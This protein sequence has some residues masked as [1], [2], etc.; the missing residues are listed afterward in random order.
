MRR[1]IITEDEKK[2]ILSKYTESNDEL[3][4]YLEENYP[5]IEIS[6]EFKDILGKYM[7]MIDDKPIILKNNFERITKK[8]DMEIVDEFPNLSDKIR[9]QT[10]KKYLKSLEF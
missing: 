1:L 5:P 9:K 7:I 6:N 10:I 3:F 8:I 4:T 2:D